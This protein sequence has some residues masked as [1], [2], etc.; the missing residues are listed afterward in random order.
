MGGPAGA[1]VASLLKKYCPKLSVVI[2]ERER[3]PREHI[4]ESQLPRV[5]AILDELEV[6]DEVEAAN[7]PIKIGAVYTWGVDNEVWDFNFLPVDEFEVTPRPASFAGQRR[8]TAFQVE[9]AKYDEILLR[10]AE[11]HWRVEVREEA[12]VV[13]VLRSGDRVTGL[14]LERGGVVRARYYVD[15]SGRAGVLRRAMGVS[16]ETPSE[17]RNVAIWDYYDNA[18]WAEEIGIGGTRV[19]VRSLP[20]GWMWFIP[21]SPSRASVGLVC[22]GEYAQ[23]ANLGARALFNRAIRDQPEISALLSDAQSATGGKIATTRNWSHL[24]KRLAGDNWW[25]VGDAAGFADP[26]LAAGLTLAHESGR[27]VAYSILE[28]DRG[29]L[30]PAWIRSSYESRQR[31]NIAQHIRFAKYWYAANSCFSDLKDYCQRIAK[32]AGL[33]FGPSEAWRWLSLGG[34]SNQ[35][36]D[37]PAFGA[38]DLGSS[39]A[40]VEIFTG[41]EV[42]F[43]IS[44]VNQLRLDL[45]GA[46]T[47]Y[48]SRLAEGRIDQVPCW[49]RNGSTLPL[50]G[51]WEQVIAALEVEGDVKRIIQRLATTLDESSGRNAYE[52]ELFKYVQVLEAMLAERWVR[53]S[54]DAS[55]PRLKILADSKIRSPSDDSSPSIKGSPATK[56]FYFLR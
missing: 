50:T 55:R 48:E 46:N 49:R 27:H 29:G 15:S 32:S 45:S 28:L 51:L 44:D 18:A 31:N 4:G 23:A 11:E 47:V 40:L 53:G 39:K 24:A 2:L 12:P 36:I 42:H 13:E 17:L 9:R 3:F 16:T 30:D 35:T 10:H 5:S 56:F 7:F 1:T 38:F 14:R 22:P 26:I 41:Q 8:H 25:L 19:Q 37:A 6:W 54:Y 34:F 43:R 52:I 33:P 21:L 20:F